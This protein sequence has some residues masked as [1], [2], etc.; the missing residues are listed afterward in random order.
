[1][2]IIR[3]HTWGLFPCTA[4]KFL[5]LLSFKY[6]QWQDGQLPNTKGTSYPTVREIG[7]SLYDDFLTIRSKNHSIEGGSGRPRTFC[8][9]V[10]ELD[11]CQIFARMLLN[12]LYMGVIAGS[13]PAAST[14]KIQ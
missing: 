8:L 1:V 5:G 6:K 2:V 7:I 13:I 4:S 12:S 3:K 14:R 11:F 10:F 9:M